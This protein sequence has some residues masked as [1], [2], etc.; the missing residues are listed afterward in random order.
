MAPEMAVGDVVDGRAD[1]YALGCVA[2][3][4]L[5][6]RLV[7]EGAG[8]MQM[9]VRRL[10]E[11]PPPLS[12]RTEMPVP[13]DLERVV[14]SCLAKS[15]DGRPRTARVLSDALAAV[16]VSPW[17]DEH[18][19]AWWMAHQPDQPGPGSMTE[20]VVARSIDRT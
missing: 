2:Y 3:Y 17:T 11:E 16:D 20:T 14:H 13:A 6:G 1:I 8:G 9:L 15:P 7:F 18:A 12:S 5:S 19:R 4:L 10:H